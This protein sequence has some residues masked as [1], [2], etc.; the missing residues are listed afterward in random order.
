MMNFLKNVG[1]LFVHPVDTYDEMKFKR[2]Y[3]WPLVL[4]L[5]A[6]WFFIEII[7]RQYSGFRFSVA[8]PDSLNIF[9]IVSRTVLPYILFCVANWA[10]CTLMDGEGR[11]NEICTYMAYALVPYVVSLVLRLVL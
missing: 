5:C 8:K 10:V 11:F 1:G 9:V 3:S 4:I 6:I 7:A 2:Y